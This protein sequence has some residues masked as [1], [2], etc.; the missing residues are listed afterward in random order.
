MVDAALEVMG[1]TIDEAWAQAV[2]DV[3]FGGAVH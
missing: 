1:A 3:G 2:K